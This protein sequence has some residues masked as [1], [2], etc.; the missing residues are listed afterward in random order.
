MWISLYSE[1]NSSQPLQLIFSL[2]AWT[3]LRLLT[4]TICENQVFENQAIEMIPIS[5]DHA[6]KITI[7]E[8]QLLD[9]VLLRPMPKG[10]AWWR[11]GGQKS[12][13]LINLSIGNRNL[14][15]NGCNFIA[16]DSFVQQH[17]FQSNNSWISMW[18]W[19]E[20]YMLQIGPCEQA[21]RNPQ[22]H[23]SLQNPNKDSH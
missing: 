5:S 7:P 3:C 16:S 17:W 15:L 1:R 10:T 14:G 12:L 2:Y 13:F 11:E 22:Y 19:K 20:L 9:P 4:I 18:I 23:I 21:L 6:V 8:M